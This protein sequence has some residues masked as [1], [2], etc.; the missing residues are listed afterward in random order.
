[1]AFQ[2]SAPATSGEPPSPLLTDSVDAKLN[3]AAEGIKHM[4]VSPLT[5]R[6]EADLTGLWYETPKRV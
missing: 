1:M 6:D 3:R 4:L 2:A 5:W